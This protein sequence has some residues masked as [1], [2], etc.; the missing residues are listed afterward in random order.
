[1]TR[2]H[3]DKRSRKDATASLA[4]RFVRAD[5]WNGFEAGEVVKVLGERGGRFVFRSHV[6]NPANGARWVEVD[7]LALPRRGLPAVAPSSDRG[8]EVRQ[9]VRRQRAFDEE[10]IVRL[11]RPRRRRAVQGTQGRFDFGTST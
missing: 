1:M 7:E 8:A 4:E 5:R 9:V 2:R 3:P 10:R 11:P 6:L